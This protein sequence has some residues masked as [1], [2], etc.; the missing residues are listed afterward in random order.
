[1]SGFFFFFFFFFSSLQGLISS[2]LKEV[3]KHFCSACSVLLVQRLFI[4]AGA[5]QWW[6]WRIKNVFRGKEYY[7]NFYIVLVPSRILEKETSIFFVNYFL[8]H[9][10]KR[11]GEGKTAG[12]EKSPV[13]R[14]G[15][16][17]RARGTPPPLFLD[18]TETR[19]AEKN[20]G[21]Q[22]PLSKG[23]DD[24][25]LPPLSRGLDLKKSPVCRGGY[26]GR[27]RGTP[28]PLFLD[29]TETRMAEKNWGGQP[30]LSKGLDDHPLPPLS[31]GLDL[32]L[33]W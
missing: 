12:L 14:G 20:W 21:G 30:P 8:G 4:K 11:T 2:L 32:E 1:M 24:H 25:P 15:Y 13:C 19:M 27:A 5:F 10:Q 18:Q 29:Q 28:P 3:C 17:G 9:Y 26:R 31:R 23:L 6:V 16:R 33:V 22:P 7:H